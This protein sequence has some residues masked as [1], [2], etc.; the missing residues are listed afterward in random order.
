MKAY[1][2]KGISSFCI[3]DETQTYTQVNLDTAENAVIKGSNPK[4]FEV[5]MSF[6]TTEESMTEEEF[7]AKKAAALL[8]INN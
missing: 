1:F 4:M 8:A 2:K 5:L 3:D 6:S 7:N